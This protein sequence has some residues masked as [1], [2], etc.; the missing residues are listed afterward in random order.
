MVIVCCTVSNRESKAAQEWTIYWPNTHVVKCKYYVSQKQNGFNNKITGA[1]FYS[2]WYLNWRQSFYGLKYMYSVI[3]VIVNSLPGIQQVGNRPV[4]GRPECDLSI[5]GWERTILSGTND[6]V[7]HDPSNERSIAISYR[8]KV[9]GDFQ[10]AITS[11]QSQLI[12]FHPSPRLLPPS[13]QHLFFGGCKTPVVQIWMRS[14]RHCMSRGTHC[15]VWLRFGPC[16]DS[17]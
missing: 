9:V 7:T 16:V 6:L 12:I 17:W 3:S 14:V 10:M 8:K 15:T 11:K 5:L 13:A 2:L 4:R 1:V